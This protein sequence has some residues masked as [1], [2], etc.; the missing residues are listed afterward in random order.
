MPQ[1]VF[2]IRIYSNM[3]VK[4]NTCHMLKIKKISSC[5]QVSGILKVFTFSEI[6]SRKIPIRVVVT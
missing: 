6:E 3:I 4:P 5:G 1:Q 2:A